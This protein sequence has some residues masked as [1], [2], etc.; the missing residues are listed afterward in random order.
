MPERTTRAVVLGGGGL[1]GV[2]WLAGYVASLQE[3][4]IQLSEAD[5]IVGTS[6]GSIAG[7]NLAAGRDFKRLAAFLGSRRSPARSLLLKLY[8]LTPTP[9]PADIQKLAAQWQSDVPSSIA[10]KQE[11]GRAAFA[12]DVMPE[13]AWLG[14]VG[15]LLLMRHWPAASLGVTAVDAET[16]ERRVFRQEDR[17]SVRRAVGASAAVPQVFPP[18]HVGGRAYID[19]GTGSVMN[20]DVAA[21]H[22]LVIVVIDHNAPK[23]GVGPLSRRAIDLEVEQL[24]AD[25][26]TVL[27]IEPDAPSIDAMGT[28]SALD[29][30]RIQPAARAGRL[31]GRAEAATVAAAWHA[32]G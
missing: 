18:V 30:D 29:P 26:S 27:V 16:G 24:R 22:D 12:A 23:T 25:G 1:T 28:M 7:A 5:L 11:A 32:A 9:S 21:G 20:A 3:A 8:G 6:A 4:G 2:A 17:V 15:T 13:R 10:S 19:G 14:F 31:Q